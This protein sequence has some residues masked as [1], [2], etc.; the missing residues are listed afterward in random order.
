MQSTAAPLNTQPASY[1]WFDAPVEYQNSY[2]ETTKTKTVI[3]PQPAKMNVNSNPGGSTVIQTETPTKHAT[4]VMSKIEN[5]THRAGEHLGIGTDT[6]TRWSLYQIPEPLFG[7][8]HA[9]AVNGIQGSAS[10]FMFIS[11]GHVCF[12]SYTNA[13]NRAIKVIIPLVNIAHIGL[14][15]RVKNSAH[16]SGIVLTPLS[17]LSMKAN[18]LQIIT[19][20]NVNHQ[21]F[22]FRKNTE[23]VFNLLNHSWNAA[24]G[25]STTAPL[26]Q[27]PM[28]QQPM[29]QQQQMPLQDRNGDGRID[30]RDLNNGGAYSTTGLVNSYQ[31]SGLPGTTHY[32]NNTTSLTKEQALAQGNL[33]ATSVPQETRLQ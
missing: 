31:G 15:Q 14:A 18:A 7:E 10:G 20:D 32:V 21:F 11:S 26:A 4:G 17:S 33:P 24:R 8:F 22:G 30:A 25:Q 6:A 16:S 1:N 23:N 13:Q 27:Q 19:N 29:M 3:P 28:M 9:K 2:K 5:L 12:S